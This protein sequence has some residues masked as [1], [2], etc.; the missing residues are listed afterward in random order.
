MQDSIKFVKEV[1][2]EDETKLKGI[3]PG[4]C[5]KIML[6]RL[7]FP[8]QKSSVNDILLNSVADGSRR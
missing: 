6:W 4:E 8:T 1:A 3:P 2:L 7:N 5:S